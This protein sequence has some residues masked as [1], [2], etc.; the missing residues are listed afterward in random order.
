[1]AAAF[2]LSIYLE[3]PTDYGEGERTY[4][5]GITFDRANELKRQPYKI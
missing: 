1:M 4:I 2:I 3:M 5:K